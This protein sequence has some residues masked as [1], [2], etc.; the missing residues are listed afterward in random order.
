MTVQEVIDELQKMP[1]KNANVIMFDGP[2]YYT[3]SRIYVWEGKD[4]QGADGEGGGAR[5]RA[6]ALP[7][8]PLRASEDGRAEKPRQRAESGHGLQCF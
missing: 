7:A 6:G 3:P 8:F 1:D 4:D 5:G 2:S